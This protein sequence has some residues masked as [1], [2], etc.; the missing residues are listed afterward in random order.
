MHRYE[1][2]IVLLFLAQT[3]FFFILY[4]AQAHR[5]ASDQMASPRQVAIA[6]NVL[7]PNKTERLGWKMA[8]YTLV[9]FGDYQCPACVAQA[10]SKLSRL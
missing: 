7:V 2:W 3:L 9:E 4:R 8:P 10:P 6:A 1:R 5:G